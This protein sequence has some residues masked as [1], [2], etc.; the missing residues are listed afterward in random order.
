MYVIK[1]FQY[2]KMK[3]AHKKKYSLKGHTH[4]YV[5]KMGSNSIVHENYWANRY[6]FLYLKI[7]IYDI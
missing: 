6:I 2:L 7:Q 1:V 5:L 4:F 3:N